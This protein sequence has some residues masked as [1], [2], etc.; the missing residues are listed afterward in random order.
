M[1]VPLDDIRDVLNALQE[2]NIKE[3]NINKVRNKG[4]EERRRECAQS[5]SRV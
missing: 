3:Q 5:L 1:K 4:K 2:H